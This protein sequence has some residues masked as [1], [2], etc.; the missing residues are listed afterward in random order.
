LWKRFPQKEKNAMSLREEE[1]LA[2]LEKAGQKDLVWYWKKK[3]KILKKFTG[4]DILRIYTF[5]VDNSDRELVR[6]FLGFDYDLQTLYGNEENPK[7][8][9]QMTWDLVAETYTYLSELAA[10]MGLFWYGL[11]MVHSLFYHFER[12]QY[13]YNA[14]WTHYLRMTTKD[15]PFVDLDEDYPYPEPFEDPWWYL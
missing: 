1:I 6:N 4:L 12:L 9:A 13:L 7:A 2:I 10:D 11:P 15:D 5:H 3:A 14:W 8:F